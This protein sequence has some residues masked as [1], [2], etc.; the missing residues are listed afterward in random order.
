MTK[1]TALVI[2]ADAWA[3]DE[4]GGAFKIASEFAIHCAGTGREV[5]YLCC[6]SKATG[7][8]TARDQ[9]VTVWR[10]PRPVSSGTTSFANF[11]THV[12]GA[13][14]ALRDISKAVNREFVFN[15]H[16][17]LPYFAGLQ[18]RDPLI[19]RRV[20]S[21]HSPL[22]DEYLANREE[23]ALGPRAQAARWSFRQI[24]KRCY[25]NS[26]LVQCD[27]MYTASLLSGQFPRETSGRVT[28]C[29]G[30]VDYERMSARLS[31]REARL[32]LRAACWQ[33]D[34]ICFFSL[35]RHARRMGLDNLIRAFSWLKRSSDSTLPKCRL[36][37][38]GDGPE[39]VSLKALAQSSG[40]SSDIHFL[41]RID[42]TEK[43]LHYRA[44]DCFVL[45]TR[46]LEGF[47]LIVLEAFAAGTAVIATPVGAI[48]EVLGD[49]GAECLTTGTE[50]EDIGRAMRAFLVSGRE[51]DEKGEEKRRLHARKFDMARVLPELELV[52][53][54]EKA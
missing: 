10:Y 24:E 16:G 8:R 3:A 54:G 32:Q 47:G 6:D 42:E 46:A 48:P 38:G 7:V 31:R 15:G 9:G 51:E 39:T 1:P 33:T 50:A 17:H 49:F 40:L 19:G 43:P 52:V 11:L 14:S 27:S 22:A 20:M 25:R 21:V 26:D 2:A 45:P 28:V 44:A 4:F 53:M 30:Y 37:L 5:H 12:K 35:R 41:G 13:G 23:G 18:R 34:D 36:I 29:P